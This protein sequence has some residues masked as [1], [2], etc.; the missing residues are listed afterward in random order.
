[1]IAAIEQ[2]MLARLRAVEGSL[3]FS[4]KTLTTFPNPWE[5]DLYSDALVQCPAAWVTFSGWNGA[6]QAYNAETGED[7]LHVT[8]SFGLMIAD[9]NRRPG[10]QYQRHGGPNPAT[11]PGSYRLLLGA[12]AALEGQ[13]L[14]LGLVKPLSCGP[15]RAVAPLVGDTKRPMSRYAVELTCT[16]PIAVTGDGETD[17]DALL[18]LHANWD[19]APF[20]DP[21]PVDRDPL[22]PGTQLPDDDHADATS[23][24]SLGVEE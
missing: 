11:E 2:A 21:V 20:G 12:V 18:R 19:L 23:V 5:A 1:M 10:E 4:W 14:N 16:F 17:P 22:E 13:S 8:G 6:V 15:A 24:V 3:G 9:E 7:E